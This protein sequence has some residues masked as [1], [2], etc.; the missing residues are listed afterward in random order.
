MDRWSLHNNDL[1]IPRRPK[2]QGI[3]NLGTPTHFKYLKKMANNSTLDPS[4]LPSSII[5]GTLYLGSFAHARNLKIFHQLNI[6]LVINCAREIPNYHSDPTIKYFKMDLNDDTHF[7]LMPFF[8]QVFDVL[9]QHNNQQQA[10]LFHCASGCSRS[11]SMVI[12]YLMKLNGWTLKQSYDYVKEHRSKIKPN[13]G[14][15]ECLIGYEKQLY[16]TMEV[17]SIDMVNYH[18]L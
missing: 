8:D 9:N 7:N 15:I 11:A 12:A 14:F 17:P 10:V 13:P 6:G 2:H 5:E 3:L 16:P 4:Q 18:Q 1:N